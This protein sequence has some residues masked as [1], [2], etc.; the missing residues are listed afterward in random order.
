MSVRT[1]H[2]RCT[3]K[4]PHSPHAIPACS[5]PAPPKPPPPQ[6]DRLTG[7]C[8]YFVRTNPKGVSEKTLDADVAA[9]DILGPGVLDAFR[10]LVSDVYLPIL[11]VVTAS[12]W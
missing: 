6:N 5:Q 2:G 12:A 9:G 11:Q 4:P 7:K 8:V 1:L 10:A 3:A